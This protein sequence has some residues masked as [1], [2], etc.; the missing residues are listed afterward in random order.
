VALVAGLFVSTPLF[1]TAEAA[2]NV[3]KNNQAVKIT[4]AEIPVRI[5][6]GAKKNR[7]INAFDYRNASANLV[8]SMMM[9]DSNFTL[10]SM[11]PSGSNVAPGSLIAYTMF[12]DNPN[13]DGDDDEVVLTFSIPAGTSFVN[14]YRDGQDPFDSCLGPDAG[15]NFSCFEDSLNDDN[16]SVTLVVAVNNP[17]AAA[18]VS[19]TA[20]YDSEDYGS[21]DVDLTATHTIVQPSGGGGGGLPTADLI[22][23]KVADSIVPGKVLAGGPGASD[24][25]EYSLF[26][27]N[28]GGTG[29]DP[30]FVAIYDVIPANTIYVPGSLSLPA[31]WTCTSFPSGGTVPVPGELFRCITDSLAESVSSDIISYRVR[32]GADIPDG[33]IISNRA[34]ITTI[35]AA[36]NTQDPNPQDNL[37]QPTSTVVEARADLR[38]EYTVESQSDACA[39]ANAALVIKV[40]NDGP[41]DARNVVLTNLLHPDPTNQTNRFLSIGLEEAPGFTCSTPSVGGTGSLTCTAERLARG[42]MATFYLRIQVRPDFLGNITY[43]RTIVTSDTPDPDP[44]DNINTY[45]LG[46]NQCADV[47]VVSKVDNPDPVVAGAELTYDI[48]VR[49][50]GPSD[51]QNVQVVDNIPAGTTF[52]NVISTGVFAGRCNHAGGVLT[53]IPP[54]GVFPAGQSATIRLIVNVNPD[55]TGEL[56]NT[57]YISTS[58]NGDNPNNNSKYENTQ[59]IT[60]TDLSIKKTGPAVV[61]A[62]NQ[63][64]YTIVV[65]NNGPSDAPTDSVTVTDTLDARLTFQSATATGAGNFTCGNIGNAMTC[66]NDAPLGVNGFATITVTFTVN[67]D[68]QQNEIILNTATV[69]SL[70]D[71]NP[72]N[73]TS[74]TSTAGQTSADLQL[75]KQAAPG[76]VVAGDAASGVITYT[77]NIKNVGPSNANAVVVSDVVPANTVVTQQPAFVNT[78]APPIA[79]TCSAASPGQMFT[80]TVNGGVMPVGAMGTLTYKVQVPADIAQNTIVTNLATIASTEVLP[81]AAKLNQE[82]TFA[83]AQVTTPDPNPAN[84]QQDPTQTLVTTQADLGITKTDSPDPVIAGQNL[85]YTIVVE[86]NGPSDAQNIVVNDVLPT[87]TS[88]VSTNDQASGFSC[89]NTNGA[90]S[91]TRA[92]LAA[93]AS[94]T[95]VLVVKV[96]PYVTGSLTNTATVASSTA[97]PGPTANSSTTTTTVDTLAN[98]T[99]TKAPIQPMVAAGDNVTY[100]INVTN[101]G[102][103]D[104]KDVVITDEWGAGEYQFISVEGTGLLTNTCTGANAPPKIVT[105]SPGDFPAGATAS[106]KVTFKVNPDAGPT[107]P[108][109]ARVTTSTPGNANSAV[110][111][112]G[113][114]ST[115]SS[116]AVTRR[117]D[118]AIVKEDAPDAANA[119]QEVTYTLTIVNNGPST[120]NAGELTVTD[121]N[122]APA[123]ASIV[124]GSLDITEAPDF[125]ACA[126]LDAGCANGGAI[127]P[128]EINIIRYRVLVNPSF[129]NGLP[130]DQLTKNLVNTATLSGAATV[131]CSLPA[132]GPADAI[133]CDTNITNNSSTKLTPVGPNADLQL[134]KIAD[135]AAVLAGGT[136]NPLPG[137]GGTG[138]ITYTITYRNNGPTDANNVRITDTIPAN[139]V[140]VGYDIPAAASGPTF[141]CAPGAPVSGSQIVCY[142]TG[143][144]PLPVGANGTIRFRV[145]VLAN[146][147]QNTLVTN[148]ATITS[149]G[150]G[151]TFATPDPNTSNNTQNPTSTL[152]NTQ[153]DLAITKSGPA[154]VTAGANLT[155][156]LSVSNNGPSDAQNV[157]VTDV[158]NANLEFISATSNP[159]IFSCNPA[160]QGGI[161]TLSCTLATLPAGGSATISVVAK[162]K[163]GTPN[164]A[165]I[166][167]TATVS[168]S[169]SDPAT[170]N[171]TS[172]TVSTTVNTQS[173]VVV[174]KNDQPDPVVAGTNLTYTITVA[175]NGASDAK[176]VRLSDVLPPETTFVSFN[177]TGIFQPANACTHSGNTV[178]CGLPASASL[179]LPAGAS[180]NLNIVAKVKPNV[181]ANTVITNTVNVS[182]LDS[183][184]VA[185]AEVL[186]TASAQTTT[187]VRHESDMTIKKTAPDSGIAGSRIDYRL[188]VGNNGPSDV[189]GDATPGSIMVMDTLPEGTSLASIPNNPFVSPGGPGGFTCSY[190]AAT[191]KV[192][193]L[194]AAGA[195]GDFQAGAN[196]EIIIKVDLAS[197]LADG[198]NLI[199]C[200]QVTLRNTGDTPENDPIGGG[201]HDDANVVTAIAGGNNESC[202]A[203]VVR[204]QADLGVGK[205]ATAVASVPGRPDLPTVP[206]PPVQPN[207]PPG[208]VKAGGYIRFDVPFGNA[209]PS[210]AVNVKLTDVVP[211]NTELVFPNTNPFTIVAKDTDG[212]AP[213]GGDINLTCSVIGQPGSQQIQCTPADNTAVSPTYVAG[214]LPAGYTGTLQFWVKVNESVTGGTIVANGANITSAPNGSIPGT[215]DPNT[216][217]N[218]TL[219][220]S[221]VVIAASNLSVTKIVQSAVTSASNPN[222]TGPIGPATTP[223]GA[224]L[225]GTAVLPGTYLTYRVVVTNNGPSDV[226]NIRLTDVLPSGLETP[227]GRV[228][229]VKYISVNPVIPSGATFTC[230]PP[231]GVNPSNNPQGNGG[232]L[233]CTAPL[234][235]ANAPN[236]TAAIDITVFID[237]ATKASLVNTATVDATINNFNLPVSGTTVLTTP[238]A[239]TSDIALTKTH[240]PDP[241]IAGTDLEYTITMTNNGP[242]AAQMVSLV[243]TIPAYQAVKSIQVIQSPDGN[244]AP[245]V[246]CAQAA[247]AAVDPRATPTSVTCTAAELPPNKKPDGTVNPAGTVVVKI[248][249]RQSAF[250]PQ[251]FPAPE[252]VQYINCVTATSMSFDPIAANSTDVCDTVNVIFRADLSIVKTDSPD[253]VIAG[254]NLTYTIEATNNGPSA[255]LDMM[256]SDPIPAGTVFVSA[257]APGSTSLITPAVDANGLV[258]ATWAGLTGPGVKRM[259]TIVVRV[260]PEVTCDTILSN[261]ATTTSLTPDPNPANNS[262]TEETTVKAQSDLMIMKSGPAEAPYSTTGYDSIVT[263]TLNFSN[264]GPSNAAGTRIVDVLPKGFEVVDLSSTVPGT[265]FS[266]STVNGISTVT[267]E[268]GIIGAANQCETT[269]PTSGTVTIKAK[270]PIKHPVLPVVNTAT[271]STTN[272]LPDPNLEDNTS[273][274]TTAITMPGLTAAQSYPA[275][276]EVSDQQPGSILFYPIY[277]SDPV[278]SNTQNTRLSLTNASQTESVCVHLFAVDGASCAVLDAFVCLTPNQTTTFLASDFDPGNSGYLMAVA[279]DCETGLPRAFNCLIGDEYVKFATGHQA[280]L[281]AEAIQSVMMFP[282][283]TDPNVTS[284]ELKFDGMFYN[285]LPRVLAAD[286]IPSTADGNS[287]ML[288]INRVGGDFQIGGATIGP[289]TGLLY[290]DAEIS[291]SFTASLGNCQ[292]RQILSNNFPRTFTPFSRVIPAGRSG[293][294][295]FWTVS[296]R[297]LFGSMINFNP[298]ANANS[299]AF[300][301]GHNLHKLT[302]SDTAT[303][304]V[305]VFIPSC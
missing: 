193:C 137:A 151:A 40:T 146:I 271:I 144:V 227:P 70:L 150:T 36:P 133:P 288:I 237:P 18:S 22:I 122:P 19:F 301:Q 16:T 206:L 125:A 124:A 57:A 291:Y 161:T 268:L 300:N 67:N 224:G 180:A 104:A 218:T 192:T 207:V 211:G 136:S 254:T 33:T 8:S 287:T 116:V 272:C 3:G 39:G 86:N 182:W 71:P 290:D 223:N 212:V 169:T 245:N 158:L 244:G 258:K 209:G 4:S 289:I 196:I 285:R 49:N 177:G 219:P 181:P 232:S 25:I 276:T 74:T 190:D 200:A 31:D 28:K 30:N 85:T 292:Y 231:T 305:P 27:R 277:T 145:R 176:D 293:W 118:V 249:V 62:G 229:G 37:S 194:N 253:P 134:A 284:T 184:G 42:E 54:N 112:E 225:T 154:D 156:T 130:V 46:V 153:A 117:T 69:S 73:N 121:P 217:N 51:A 295:K 173:E 60:R 44:D 238:V 89:T 240:T 105:C 5:K 185:G 304:R 302:L 138:D 93:G 109:T 91:C 197:S 226:S 98:F 303:I 81:I 179:T 264:K 66:S 21:G 198:T 297:A 29:P 95:I 234:L 186:N 260:C 52:A 131:A 59:V 201:H 106:V 114:L 11:P 107:Q 242:S 14:I 213:L 189:N 76:S 82:G 188:I 255:A 115:L 17:T 83:A 20:T 94:G 140:F 236:N 205:T 296:D 278:N 167:N 162:V 251:P 2:R 279:V 53:C 101:N 10:T 203:T 270:V 128:G 35:E 155:Y 248:V 160:S 47:E 164:G 80:C 159:A 50:N 147:A 135:P 214:V 222:Q 230:A 77:I 199:N 63:Y 210:D 195:A 202:D 13:G 267:A 32:V 75:S 139:T 204:T 283:G 261:T 1:D 152:I 72:D 175:N 170:A 282:G 111:G 88:L 157:V 129:L 65:R 298:Q 171:N 215:P 243:D 233:V 43:N 148:G 123:D 252:P 286:N 24:E 235:S 208:A 9:D 247:D 275:R 84:N 113:G 79:L 127:A 166:T 142:P 41:S 96:A 239:P 263:Y 48:V 23:N 132:P 141:V 55:T 257:S 34:M 68:V 7:F 269:F 168:S 110:P 100:T 92:T 266:V 78:G 103:S 61:T 250:T 221:T 280:N 108:N 15:G 256:I 87:G 220:T 299:G 126:D 143:D 58:T 163:S 172:N 241:V 165:V 228:L 26:F 281:G 12:I 178:T 262:D 187:T 99:I 274:W 102:P 246:T 265:T 45:S 273:S 174:T 120:V 294:M 191:R 216:A 97:D 90:V 183:N 6:S 38:V 149:T 119:G 64:T 56:D 259:L